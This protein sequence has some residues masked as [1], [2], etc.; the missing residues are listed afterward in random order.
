MWI[1]MWL[2]F[3]K[4]L[5]IGS[6]FHFPWEWRWGELF[7]LPYI[8]IAAFL[9]IYVWCSRCMLISSIIE[10]ERWNPKPNLWLQK[11]KSICPW[12]SSLGIS[13]LVPSKWVQKPLEKGYCLKMHSSCPS[14][15]MGFVLCG[16]CTDRWPPYS[17]SEHQ[18]WKIWLSSTWYS[19]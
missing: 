16:I 10:Y 8:L 9:S 17:K 2:K 7:L 4:T 19:K 14:I 1:I 5:F 6:I 11:H 3:Q 13:C 15:I 12:P 18:Y